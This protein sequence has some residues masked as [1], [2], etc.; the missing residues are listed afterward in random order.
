MKIPS[1][2]RFTRN[3]LQLCSLALLLIVFP[4]GFAQARET[5]VEYAKRILAEPPEG[6][7]I[8]PD[9][10]A[11]VLRATNAYLATKG[12]KPLKPATETLQTAARAQAMDLLSQGGMGHVSSNGYNFESRVHAFFPGQMFLSAMAEN[13]ARLRNSSLS[14]SAQAQ[15][16]VQQWITSASHRKNMTNRTYVMIAVG[17]VSRGNDIY[18]VQ[19]FSGPAVKT[20]M[21]IGGQSQN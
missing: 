10:E 11:G 5:Y 18:A 19:I 2:F 8:R 1:F 21:M 14:D 17:V 15:A 3:R 9:L 16:L 4:A 7:A 13:A 6:A 20:N 12:L